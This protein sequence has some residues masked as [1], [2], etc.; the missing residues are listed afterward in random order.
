MLQ[1]IAVERV[2]DY[3]KLPAETTEHESSHLDPKWPE[4]GSIQAETLNLKYHTD[5]PLVL[6]DLSFSI[7]PK[8]K[9]ISVLVLF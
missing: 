2:R 5:A 4:H 6:K 1:M 7:K 8:E 9:V 3:S